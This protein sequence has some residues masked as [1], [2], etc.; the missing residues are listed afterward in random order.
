MNLTDTLDTAVF[1]LLGPFF[2]GQII[3]RLAYGFRANGAVQVELGAVLTSSDSAS[4]E[5]W[6]AGT[7]IIQRSQTIGDG[8][9][10]IRLAMGTG[11]AKSQSIA[12]G[13]MVTDTPRYLVVRTVGSQAAVRVDTWYSAFCVEFSRESV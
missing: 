4:V 10:V 1:G 11:N 6:R 13:L 9:P 3:E 12:V 7:P 8:Q 5:S 2:R